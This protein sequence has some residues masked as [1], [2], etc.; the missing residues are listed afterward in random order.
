MHWMDISDDPSDNPRILLI[1]THMSCV[2]HAVAY[3]HYDP[4]YSCRPTD[5][6][7]AI[8]GMNDEEG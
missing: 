3:E 2:Y 7:I 4:N 5:C 6:P 1:K 8:V